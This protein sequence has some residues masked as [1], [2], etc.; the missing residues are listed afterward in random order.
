MNGLYLLLITC[1]L[2]QTNHGYLLMHKLNDELLV[3][4]KASKT[5]STRIIDQLSWLGAA[6][7][8]STAQDRPSFF[9]PTQADIDGMLSITY[10]ETPWESATKSLRSMTSECWTSLFRNPAIASGFPICPRGGNEGGLEIPLEMMIGLGQVDRMTEFDGQL[11][12]TSFS[13]LLVPVWKSDASVGW[14]FLRKENQQQVLFGDA[15]D[16]AEFPTRV[17]LKPDSLLTQRHFVGWTGSALLRAGQS[18]EML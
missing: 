6:C 16:A 18:G 13:T 3:T 14:H 10:Q 4:I 11:M 9:K 2:D 5:V 15:F 1:N 7:R 12:L 17:A 8:A